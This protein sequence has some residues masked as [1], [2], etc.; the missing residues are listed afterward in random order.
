MINIQKVRLSF[1]PRI[2]NF[3]IEKDY[4]KKKDILEI[5]CSTS[6]Y[7]QFSWKLTS[8]MKQKADQFN[9]IV[10][11]VFFIIGFL[12]IFIILYFK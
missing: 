1:W 4:K 5:G 7:S 8:H 10:F 6:F 12:N 2:W 11:E 3:P 9:I